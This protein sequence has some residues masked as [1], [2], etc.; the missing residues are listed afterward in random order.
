MSVFAASLVRS[1]LWTFWS[2]SI[3][4]LFSCCRIKAA[5]L[6]LRIHGNASNGGSR[7]GPADSTWG[8]AV[9]LA[10]AAGGTE[11]RKERDWGFP[12]PPALSSPG[13]ALSGGAL[14]RDAPACPSCHRS[15]HSPA[16]FQ[17]SD[18]SADSPAPPPAGPCFTSRLSQRA[19]SPHPLMGTLRESCADP[20]QGLDQRAGEGRSS[21]L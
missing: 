5:Q 6:P 14:S 7:R 3:Y 18:R 17:L 8:A 2:F 10:S 4:R 1:A 16:R 11:R 19:S 9:R 21:P 15:S 20:P 12:P 13:R